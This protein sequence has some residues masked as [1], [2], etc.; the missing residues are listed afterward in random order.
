MA[1]WILY[2][3]EQGSY[4]GIAF[5]MFIENVFPP[6]PSELIMGLGGMAVARG[7]MDFW[8]L[9]IVG[10]VG[11]TVGNYVWFLAGDKLGYH[12]LKP[13]VDRWGRWLTMDWDDVEKA[14][15]F[16][17][18]HGQWIVFV[19]RLS[20]FLRTIVSLPAGMAHM[21]HRTFLT[22]TFA[23]TALWN[24]ALI[25]GG[26]WLSIYLDE[27]QGWLNWGIAATVALAVGIYVWRIATWKPR[28]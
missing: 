19:L 22:F 9:L 18:K 13:L 27:A 21:K 17:Q 6:I 2:L 4:W 5:L 24:A 20:P 23:G 28:R 11:S 7:S 10:T 12:R 1:A 8:P 16:F 14:S 15:H 26:H 3:I 25:K